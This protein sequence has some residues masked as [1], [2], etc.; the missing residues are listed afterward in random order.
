MWVGLTNNFCPIIEVKKEKTNQYN[1]EKSDNCNNNKII[2]K[3]R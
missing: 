1:K 3:D 2:S